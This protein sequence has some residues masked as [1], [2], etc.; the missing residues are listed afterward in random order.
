[1]F[2]YCRKF[3]G[4][5]SWSLIYNIIFANKYNLTSYFQFC[6]HLVCFG[7]LITEGK[8]SRTLLHI[9]GKSKQHCLYADFSGIALKLIPCKMS[10]AMCLL[11]ITSFALK[12][13]IFISFF[14]EIFIMVGYWI[15]VKGL[16]CI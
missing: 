3:P 5:F 12:Y 14:K 16:S 6:V 9:Y 4:K 7:C 1:M 15:F 11:K 8:T 2:F 13:V 10:L